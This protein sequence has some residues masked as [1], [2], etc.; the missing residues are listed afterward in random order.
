MWL[1]YQIVFFLVLV[2]VGPILL[3]RRGRHYLTSIGGRL[4]AYKGPIPDS[5][6]WI[7]A[8][9]V[10]EV[11]VAST[12]IQ[13]L[14]SDIPLLIT[15][16]TP[17]GQDQA[18]KSLGER[19]AVTYLPFDL[20]FAIGRFL[21]RF[22][23]SG[24]IL[25]EGDLWPLLLKR[26]ENQDLPILVVNG[27]ISDHSFCR[28]HRL[29]PVLG[30]LFDHVNRFGM[31]TREDGER[32][33]RLK[34]DPERIEVLGNLKFDSSVPTP[35]PEIEAQLQALAKERAILIAGSTMPGE[36][37]AV[38][39]AFGQI[40][41]GER[42]M[43]VLAPRHPERWSQVETLVEGRDFKCL[44]RTALDRAD[45]SPDVILLDTLGELASLYAIALGSFI[46]GTLVPTGGHNPVEAAQHGSAV[47]VG[48]S[49][50]NFR[51]IATVFSDAE[52]WRQVRGTTE[53]AGAWRDWL[54]NPAS[55]KALGS[56]GQMV[57]D[58]NGGALER[59]LTFLQPLV[60]QVSRSDFEADQTDR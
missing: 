10:G 35:L 55:A 21:R 29:R 54:T 1:L 51:E 43:L 49:M 4:G 31:Q 6:L 2:L 25:V 24:L 7:H 27:R 22:R 50:E 52:A 60:D 8:V 16:I 17:T 32:L 44:R 12:L 41:G 14:P 46:G 20:D 56:R 53:L 37:E 13:S 5:P 40:G 39:E 48:P 30:P 26:V 28:M 36:E 47:V 33:E 58:A 57:V 18:Q 19:A 38:L 34:V 15:T 45:S 23:P 9:S 3:I 11:A 42:A 59:T